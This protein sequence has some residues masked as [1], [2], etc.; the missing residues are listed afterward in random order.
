MGTKEIVDDAIANG[1][2][3]I[4]VTPDELFAAWE[5]EA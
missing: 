3:T 1:T 5:N 2:A 4:Y